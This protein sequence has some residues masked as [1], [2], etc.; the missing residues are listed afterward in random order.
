MAHTWVTGIIGFY[1]PC[2]QT[3]YLRVLYYSFACRC[4]IFSA[5]QNVASFTF[6]DALLVCRT[7]CGIHME[8]SS[9]S[10]VLGR[11]RQSNLT[12]VQSL[13]RIPVAPNKFGPDYLLAFDML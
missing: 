1:L 5:Y 6:E 8:N 12:T 9:S 13:T 3:L 11:T 4:D 2:F 10:F 7:T